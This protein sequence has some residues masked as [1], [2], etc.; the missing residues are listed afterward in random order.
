VIDE[1]ATGKLLKA[2][3]FTLIELL[4]VIAIIGILAALLLPALGSA[5]E[6][7]R[8][9]ACLGNLR[10]WAL[11]FGLYADDWNDYFPFEGNSAKPL[12]EVGTSGFPGNA[13]AWYNV[14]PPYMGQP[15]LVQLYDSD[16]KPTP[17]SKSIWMCPSGTSTVSAASLTLSTPLFNYAFNADMDPNNTC[18]YDCRFKRA[19]MDQPSTTIL[20]C[21]TTEGVYSQASGA[22]AVARH[23]GGTN[24]VMGDGRAQWIAFQDFCRNGNP[25]CLNPVTSTDSSGLGDWKSGTKY[26]WFPYRGAPV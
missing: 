26:H 15:S 9:V 13:N 1:V 17:R 6:K 21:E 23:S 10:Q 25:G 3:A 2:R 22:N 7:A 14:L 24:F 5:R 16:R 20:L 11:T 19:Q 4:V 8:S 18:G 12:N